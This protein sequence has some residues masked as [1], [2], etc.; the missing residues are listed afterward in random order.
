MGL[1][2]T[3]ILL[4]L[5]ISSMH[6]SAQQIIYASPSDQISLNANF[7]EGEIQWQQSEDSS[8]WQDIESAN[9][10][11]FLFTISTI[12]VYLRARVDF[13]SCDEPSYSELIT[14]LNNNN[15]DALYWSDPDTWL[16]N[17][18]PIAGEVVTIPE[19]THIILNENTPELGGLVINGILQFEQMDLELTSEWIAVHGTLQAGSENQPFTYNAIITLT[20]TDTNES[21]MG[22][23]TRG[24]MVMGGNLE[25]HGAS[26]EVTWT[27]INAH[28]EAGTTTLQLIENAGW[29][30]GDEI[31]IGPTDY[32]NA[33]NGASVTQRVSLTAVNNNELTLNSGLNAH[34]WGLLQYATAN[35]M[36]LTPG[37]TV[38]SPIP[39]GEFITPK[40]L[41]ERAP[42]GNLT[43][44]IVIQSPDDDLWRNEGFGVHVMIMPGSTAKVDGVEIKRGGQRARLRRYPFHWHMLSYS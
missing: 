44:N 38:E 40:I 22:M 30:A 25:L 29:S 6:L 8:D 35:G 7:E 36:S 3:C 43:R 19:G 42:V 26:P 13:E 17:N 21:H 39:D 31:V 33:G 23:G 10:N 4:L 2:H 16:P 34:R 18:K 28:A 9:T 14:V 32:F 27:K 20:D 24:L 11:N 1:K 12:P 5:G 41:D 15:N 37:N